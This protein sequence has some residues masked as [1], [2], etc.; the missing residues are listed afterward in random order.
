MM[1]TIDNMVD[2]QWGKTL[3]A[4]TLFVTG[5][6]WAGW[7]SGLTDWLGGLGFGMFTVSN[8]FGVTALVGGAALFYSALT[9]DTARIEMRI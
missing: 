4:A 9:G 7:L 6:G 3:I 8:L 5:L 2:S 1:E